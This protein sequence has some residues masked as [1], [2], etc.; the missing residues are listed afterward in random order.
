MASILLLGL[1]VRVSALLGRGFLDDEITLAASLEKSYGELLHSFGGP[2]TQPLYLLLGKTSGELFG[3][4]LGIEAALRLPS[5]LFGVLAIWLI[6]Q[7]TRELFGPGAAL[8]AALLLAVHPFHQ[9]YSQM[10]VGYGIAGT[11]S[12]GSVLAFVRFARAP[13][14]RAAALYAGWTA[15]AIYCHLGCLGV[16]FAEVLALPF[17]IPGSLRREGLKILGAVT[18]AC[19]VGILLYLPVLGDLL[20]FR[21]EWSGAEGGLQATLIP[22]VLTG[23]AG[24]AGL[25]IYVYLGV[26]LVGLLAAVSRAKDRRSAALLLLW[27][28]GV[29]CFYLV[30]AAA[31]PP[32]AFAR[33]FFV[34]LPAVVIAAALG[35]ET[36]IQ[37]LSS[38]RPAWA[39]APAC[40]LLLL[41]PAT[42]LPRTAEI[43]WGAKGTPWSELR[44]HLVS[45]LPEDALLVSMPMRFNA[46]RGY[47][48]QRT[49]GMPED[50]FYYR[51]A[52]SSRALD[53]PVVFVV[54]LV[55]FDATIW[56]TEYSRTRFGITSV[57]MRT[58]GEA[59]EQRAL[60]DFQRVTRAVLNYVHTLPDPEDWIFWREDPQHQ[61]L[62][63][64]RNLDDLYS[65]LL[66][67]TQMRMRE[68]RP[69]K[70]EFERPEPYPNFW[71]L[72]RPT[73]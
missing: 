18:L 27:P 26:A 64:R 11:L 17:L 1:V 60:R 15:G 46:L 50:L 52:L 35:V 30:N 12:L 56:E 4:V 36:L 25:R 45:D 53:R 51:D 38:S 33:F 6:A 5:V 21:A 66:M 48:Y 55:P 31:H 70:R 63:N 16:V 3:D 44:T 24:G 58:K 40:A 65:Q 69:G 47:Y 57:L 32:W 54:D 13:S 71:G 7:L 59:N 39:K 2:L 72:L 61:N 10:A 37:A 34:A 73:L 29:F 23:F 42:I 8:W 20:A 14:L 9:F 41:L 67:V 19:T 49:E 68:G 22:F 28:T 62:F 43:A